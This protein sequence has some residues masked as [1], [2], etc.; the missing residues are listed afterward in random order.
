[1]FSCVVWWVIWFCVYVYVGCCMP[2]S[3]DDN[4]PYSPCVTS[5]RDATT[6]GGCCEGAAASLCQFWVLL[7]QITISLPD[8]VKLCQAVLHAMYAS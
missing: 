1:M 8:H 6:V 2:A 5:E 7:T 3:I 4:N